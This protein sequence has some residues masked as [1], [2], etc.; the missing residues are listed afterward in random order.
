MIE[1][2]PLKRKENKISRQ[3]IVLEDTLEGGIIE[4]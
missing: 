2:M 1:E 4:F 3:L